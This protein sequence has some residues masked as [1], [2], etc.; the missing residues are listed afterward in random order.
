M[1]KKLVLGSASILIGMMILSKGHQGFNLVMNSLRSA[2]FELWSVV[3]GIIFIAIIVC[4]SYIIL[5]GNELLK[6]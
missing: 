5:K 4:G 6:G 1:D 2:G 3:A